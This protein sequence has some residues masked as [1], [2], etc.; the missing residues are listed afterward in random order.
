MARLQQFY[1]D[2]VVKKLMDERGYKNIMQ[3]PRIEKVTINMGVG[4]A[5][6]DKKV[7]ENALADMEK[8][9]GQKPVDPNA[10]LSFTSRGVQRNSKRGSVM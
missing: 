6:G 8:I 9:S 10:R 3:V 2:T 4:E 7:I 1:K 5:I